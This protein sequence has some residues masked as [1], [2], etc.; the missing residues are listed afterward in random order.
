MRMTF[1]PKTVLCVLLIPIAA[2]VTGCE[3]LGTAKTAPDM[4]AIPAE[5]GELVAVTPSDS[6]Y[7]S[8]LW[9]KQADQSI[10]AVRVNIARKTIYAGT[11]RFPRS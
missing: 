11:V 7:Q 3:K 10:V 6:P 2:A 5:M 4:P 8:V 1:T 9:F